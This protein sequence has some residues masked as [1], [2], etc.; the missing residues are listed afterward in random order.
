MRQSLRSW[1]WRVPIEQEVEEELAFHLEM[2]R[3]EGRPIDPADVERVRK[4]CLE[5]ARRRD[6]EMR[7]TQWFGELRGDVR[8]ALRQLRQAPAFTAVAA[9]TLALGIGA[10][11]AI[12]ALVDAT[13]L[14]PVP[15]AEPEAL[16]FVHE[17]SAQFPRGRTSSA[18]FDDWEARNRTFDSLAGVFSYARR[19]TM[20]DGSVEEV[21]AQQ[22]TPRFFDA[23]RIRPIAGRTFRP[24]DE[25]LP[26]N[27]TVI[28]ERLWRSRFDGDSGVVGRIVQIDGLPFTVL[29]IVPADFQ[30]L[31]PADLWTVWTALPGMDPRGLRFLQAFGRLKPGVSIDAAQSDMSAIAA[32]LETEHV[33]NKGRVALVEPLGDVIV[34]IQV[35]RTAVLFLGVVGFVLLMCCANV[36]NLLLARMSTRA[37]ELA[38]RSA[39]GAGRGRIVTQMLTESIVLAVLGGLIGL[40]IGAAILRAAPGWIPVGLLPPS[41]TLGFDG[42][43]VAFCAVATLAVGVLFGL[44]PAWQ[45]TG[46]RLVQVMTAEGRGTTKAGGRMRSGLVIAEV[47]AAVLLLCGAGLL[48]RSLSALADVEGGA[49]AEDALTLQVALSYG[50]PQSRHKTPDSM[51]EFYRRIEQEVSGLPGVRAA[52]WGSGLPLGGSF[53]SGFPVTLPDQPE[54]DTRLAVDY[55]LISPGY[56]AALDVPVLAGRSFDERDSAS[57]PPVCLVSADFVRKHLNGRP[58]IGVRLAVAPMGLARAQPIVREIVGV[59]APIRPSPDGDDTDQLYVPIAQNPWANSV[60]VVRPTAGSASALAPAVRAAIARIDREQPVT[61]VLTLD[62]VAWTTIARPRFRAVLV[63]IFATLALVLAMVGVFG[64][65]AYSVQQRWREFGVRI[66]LGASMSHVLRLVAGAAA[67]VVGLGILAGFVAAAALSSSISAFLFG[68]QPLDAVTFGGVATVLVV[69]GAV[70]AIVPAIRASRVDPVVAFRND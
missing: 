34:G 38:I 24:E 27:V 19:V 57:A 41:A 54:G 15:F 53:Y 17:G 12:F 8:F 50:L 7:L 56:L 64:V 49:R 14:R 37:R 45:S 33:L 18:N 25:A 59:V 70:A 35:R 11:S 63:V 65:L 6:R 43:V 62:E 61:R 46:T 58:P 39:L 5:I 52:G 55:M 3:R 66:A 2:R 47:A 44:A 30:F 20:P 29:G 1:L 16:V 67:R 32:Q 60:L 22:V 42:R 23:L 10:N 9:L 36:A 68:V 26:P 28:S 51:H 4:A 69:T 21:P 40:G 48:L 13:L 31:N